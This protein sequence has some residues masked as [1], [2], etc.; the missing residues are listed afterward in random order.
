MECLYFLFFI[1]K[2]F[3]S[4]AQKR[5]HNGAVDYFDHDRRM[6]I[7]VPPGIPFEHYSP[8]EPCKNCR[9]TLLYNKGK[10]EQVDERKRAVHYFDRLI[11]SEKESYFGLHTAGLGIWTARLYDYLS[12]GI[13]PVITSDGVILPFEKEFFFPNF[14]LSDKKKKAFKQ[15]LYFYVCEQVLPHCF[16]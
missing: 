10:S 11:E 9:G 13:I 14:L 8:T 1:L 5:F 16:V 15:F 6:D 7:V 12:K 2:F 4:S 3:L